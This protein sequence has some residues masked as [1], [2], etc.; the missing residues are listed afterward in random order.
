MSAVPWLS[1]ISGISL[2][3]FWMVAPNQ[4]C[5]I[6]EQSCRFSPSIMNRVCHFQPA[7]LWVFTAN[8]HQIASITSGKKYKLVKLQFSRS[9]IRGGRGAQA[10]RPQTPTLITQGSSIFIV[11]LP[12]LFPVPRNDCFC[13]SCPILYFFIDPS[14][15][16]HH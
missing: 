12:S 5:N 2:L 13:Q 8:P 9:E 1:L 4:D 3:N 10:R 6:E 14:S 16:H 7:K 11:C 15:S